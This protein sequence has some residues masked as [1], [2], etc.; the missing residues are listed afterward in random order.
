M[1][2]QV[3]FDSVTDNIDLPRPA[4]ASSPVKAAEDIIPSS[5]MVN[6]EV[7]IIGEVHA[8]PKASNMLAKILDKDESIAP[9]KWKTNLELPN[10]EG[11]SVDDLH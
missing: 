6:D 4:H 11:L 7:N 5:A 10:L 9:E 3:S 1:D 2:S 8:S